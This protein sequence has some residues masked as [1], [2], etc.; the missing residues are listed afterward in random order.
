MITTKAY[1]T[2]LPSESSNVF[3]V[4]I[5]LMSDHV[6]DE[7]IF[8]ALLCAPPESYNAYNVGDCVFVGFEDDKYNM[9]IIFGKLYKDKP[10]KSTAYNLLNDLKVTDTA[11]L[12]ENTTFGKFSVKDI[13]N[14][15]QGAEGG[16][17]KGGVIDPAVLKK[18]VQW[19]VTEREDPET[20]EMTEVY[21][22]HIRVMTGEEY[23]ELNSG[24]SEDFDED[25]FN[26][27]LYFLSSLP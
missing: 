16:G 5:P 26:H 7:A 10:E 4:N 2:E 14:L 17:G 24:E 8:D 15:Y 12:P 21:A 19:T 23:D 1:I 18:Y 3:K 11:E 13:F 6:N 27:T 25:E 22:D 20:H 9:A